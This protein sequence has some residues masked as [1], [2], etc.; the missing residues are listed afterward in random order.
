[1]VITSNMANIIR[2]LLN[3]GMQKI[4]ISTWTNSDLDINVF[5][6]KVSH[7]AGHAYN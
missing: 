2:F 1:M 3:Y 5:I 6:F 4:A 7:A